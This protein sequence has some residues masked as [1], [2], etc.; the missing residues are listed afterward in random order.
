MGSTPALPILVLRPQTLSG[1][2]NGH[3]R[4][5]IVTNG[6]PSIQR[7]MVIAGFSAAASSL[8]DGD[9]RLASGADVVRRRRRPSPT[10]SIDAH[11]SAI[12]TPSRS[13]P[14]P[15]STTDTGLSPNTTYLYRV[16]AVNSSGP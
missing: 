9:Q 10:R 1:L 13:A 6:I 3:Y 5:T 15:T 4:V 7:L 11:L 8:G 16:R 12:H 14:P 2:A